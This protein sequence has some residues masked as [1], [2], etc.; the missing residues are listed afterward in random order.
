MLNLPIS[1]DG[2]LWGLSIASQINHVPLA[3]TFI[4]QK[5]QPPFTLAS[6]RAAAEQCGFKVRQ[7]AVPISQ[8]AK[9]PLPCLVTLIPSVEAVSMAM[10]GH[11]AVAQSAI[12]EYHI[13]LL[14][15]VGEELVV[16][17]EACSKSTITL[18]REVF[19]KRFAGEALIITTM[20]ADGAEVLRITKSADEANSKKGPGKIGMA[21]LIPQAAWLKAMFR[22]IR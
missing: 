6:F 5:Y 10:N 9:L 14:Q 7:K 20:P 21:W 18:N 3:T 4:L 16:F 11:T 15:N 22:G 19:E 1:R 17:A 13:A 2:F 12:P 8:L